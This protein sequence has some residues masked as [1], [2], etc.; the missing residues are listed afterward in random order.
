MWFTS[1]ELKNLNLKFLDVNQPEFMQIDDF[2]M[3]AMM[4]KKNKL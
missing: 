1:M 3:H 4:A 2:P